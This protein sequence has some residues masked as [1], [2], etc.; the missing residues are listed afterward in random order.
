MPKKKKRKGL[1]LILSAPSG[2]GKTTV[3]KA[4]LKKLPNLKQSISATTRPRRKG[5]RNGRDYFFLTEEVFLLQRKEKSFLEWA[6]VFDNFYGTPRSFVEKM[7]DK[8]FD[9]ILTIDVQGAR[10]IKKQL[11][12]AVSVF[13]LPP[14]IK[15][16][17]KRLY[18]RKTDSDVVI[19]KRLN[20]ARAEL[21][22]APLYDYVVVNDVLKE[23]IETVSSIINAE[24]YRV[25]RN[26]EVLNG[27]RCT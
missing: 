6:K 18:G 2:C 12:E 8:G 23:T 7:S 26:E 24:K 17:E 11:K 21:K 19:K 16:L 27:L 10:K 22:D 3:E 4:L 9:V 13:L 14:S 25:K 15:E 20:I 5:E 1:V